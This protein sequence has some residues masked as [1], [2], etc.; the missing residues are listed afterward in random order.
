MR[1]G[2]RGVRRLS[3]HAVQALE[4]VPAGRQRRID[5][6][7]A[8]EG[9]DRLGCLLQR[10]VAVTA[11]LV[12]A[13]EAGMQLFK[14]GERG[15]RRGDVAEMTLRQRPQVQD[16]AILGHGREQRLGRPQAGGELPLR[17]ETRVFGQPQ[18]PPQKGD[19][20]LRL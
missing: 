2:V 4:H 17:D 20:C 8:Q 14:R 7:A 10:D 13:A 15:E 19:S 1:G 16:V 6:H 9:V 18:V 5:V 12:E 11:L 3:G